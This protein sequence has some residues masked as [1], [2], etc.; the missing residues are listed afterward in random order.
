MIAD[1]YDAMLARLEERFPGKVF[2]T[3]RVNTN[4]EYVRENYVILSGG[5]P[6]ETGSARHGRTQIL[7][8]DAVF[9]YTVRV[10]GTSSNTVLDMLDAVNGQLSQWTPT[11]PGRN[12]N[13]LHYPPR[14][15]PEIRTENS[16]KP[17]LFYADTEWVL[18]SFFTNNGS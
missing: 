13:R 4:G 17:P 12:C 18:R 5:S 15:R 6:A 10:V 9:D 3:A 8:D 16:V 11:I 14:Q 1:H 2:D 7:N